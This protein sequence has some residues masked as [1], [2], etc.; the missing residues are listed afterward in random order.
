M[1]GFLSNVGNGVALENR[2]SSC[3]SVD[4][5]L[6]MM[7]MRLTLTRLIWHFDLALKDEIEPAYDHNSLSAG[8]LLL[9]VRGRQF[10]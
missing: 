6:A 2:T 3:N 7:E 9:K 8:Q 1:P 10:E 5:S 4:D